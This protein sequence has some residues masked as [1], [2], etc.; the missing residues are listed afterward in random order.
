[1]KL[2]NE[3]VS[4]KNPL[5]M[6]F[7]GKSRNCC[8]LTLIEIL[9]SLALFGV[10]A[11]SLFALFTFL[12]A[13]SVTTRDLTTVTEMLR[14]QVEQALVLP[15]H[16]DTNL[17]DAIDT[18]VTPEILRIAGDGPSATGTLNPKTFVYAYTD[19]NLRR[20]WTPAF[21]NYDFTLSATTSFSDVPLYVAAD[22]ARSNSD[23]SGAKA[24]LRAPLVR[25]ELKI[26][27][28]L[29]DNVSGPLPDRSLKTR[30]VSGDGGLSSNTG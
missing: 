19:E 1:M 24:A 14:A 25:G 28:T 9:I 17:T 30:N 12:H 3:H 6:G 26:H 13:Q 27:T 5:P 16:V 20:S 8:A 18:R 29:L 21:R 4:L 11:G 2:H 7:N 22:A 10:T 23:L 15:Y